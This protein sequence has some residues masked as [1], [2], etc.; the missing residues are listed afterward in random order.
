MGEGG[1]QADE[2]P[3]VI[4]KIGRA[5]AFDFD[6]A[7]I[8][9]RVRRKAALYR[10]EIDEWLECGARLPHGPDGAVELA[11]G[12]IAAAYHRPYGAIGCEQQ[13]GGLTCAR[14]AALGAH[15][16]L[17]RIARR[18]LKSRVDGGFD[19][20]IAAGFAGEHRRNFSD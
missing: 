2:P 9:H 12:V 5:P 1:S 6:W 8:N 20:Q 7:V 18:E 4:A 17:N 10:G 13:K 3:V 11:F 16:G 14:G 19:D 15:H